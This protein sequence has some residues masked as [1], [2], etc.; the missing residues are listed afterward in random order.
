MA[1]TLKLGIA[2]LGNAGKAVLRDLS[3]IPE[4]I[5][6]AVADLRQ[7]AL[8]TCR[9]K[10]PH[11]EIHTSVETMCQSKNLDALWIATPNEFLAYSGP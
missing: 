3:A 11:V 8:E 4:V 1:Q 7:E 5:L 10:N 9:A 2:G 6:G